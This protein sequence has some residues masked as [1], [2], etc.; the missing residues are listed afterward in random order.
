MLASRSSPRAVPNPEHLL[1]EVIHQA[2][3]PLAPDHGE[4]VLPGEVDA[5]FMTERSGWAGDFAHERKEMDA[6]G[7]HEMLLE[8]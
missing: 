8:V 2:P 5:S 3:S 7:P 1:P 4:R 6:L